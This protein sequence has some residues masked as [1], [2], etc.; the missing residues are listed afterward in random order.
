MKRLFQYIILVIFSLTVSTVAYAATTLPSKQ[1]FIPK[2][3]YALTYPGI[4]GKIQCATK[5]LN[6]RFVSGFYDKK[7]KKGYFFP[8]DLSALK[9]LMQRSAGSAKKKYTKQYN[10]EKQK[11]S[12]CAQGRDIF[13]TPTP[14][15][16]PP[17]AELDRPLV[18]EDINHLYRRAGLGAPPSEAYQF[19]GRGAGEAVDYMMTFRDEPNL[20][21]E[22]QTWLDENPAAPTYPESGSFI[23]Q[24]GLIAYSMLALRKTINPFQMHLALLTLGDR[25]VVSSEGITEGI[26]PFYLDYLKLLIRGAQDYDFSTLVKDLGENGAMIKYLSLDQSTKTS[27]NEN[28]ARELMEL[29]TLGTTAQD[30]TPNY[31]NDDIRQIAKAFTGWSIQSNQVTYKPAQADLTQKTIFAGTPWQG[32]VVNGRNVVD[33]ILN[34]HPGAP[35]SLARFFLEHYLNPNIDEATVNALAE[36][37]STDHFNMKRALRTLLVSRE[38][39]AAENRYAT[40]KTLAQR[41]IHFWRALDV[42]AIQMPIDFMDRIRKLAEGKCIPTKLETVFG[43]LEDKDLPDGQELVRSYNQSVLTAIAGVT[44]QNGW[45]FS[46]FFPSAQPTPD[47]IITYLSDIFGIELTSVQR[48]N[49]L[50]YLN[51]TLK[52]DKVTLLPSPFNVNDANQVKRRIAGLYILF[53]QLPQLSDVR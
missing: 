35:L 32:S 36:I 4:P 52:A 10:L 30:G 3:S 48:A 14:T 9:K 2:D 44:S 1:A 28:Y 6:P 23:S 42:P 39:Y 53:T 24:N 25:L 47:D 27:P 41:L 20:L 33:H 12:I 7:R 5:S 49:M 43:C 8:V 15:P 45:T 22:A 17:L 21:A 31:T 50:T 16:V 18:K 11:Q 40:H 13:V 46:R 38:F 34:N 51:N 19:I 29:F 37:L 26:R